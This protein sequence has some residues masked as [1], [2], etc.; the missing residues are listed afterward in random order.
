MLRLLHSSGWLDRRTVAVKVQFTLFSPTANL[1]T[2]VTLLTER[3]P[4]GVLLPSAKVQ[5]VRVYR[6][7]AVWDYVVM[8]C[9]VKCYNI[10][11]VYKN[12]TSSTLSSSFSTAEKEKSMNKI[13]QI[14]SQQMLQQH[15]TTESLK[16]LCLVFFLSSSSSSLSCLCC[17]SVIKCA[18]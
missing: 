16:V 6:T 10:Y 12:N 14:Y 11:F 18:H 8:V 2:S 13:Y 7:P 15:N 1:F 3:T 9:Q 4:T 5:S 17:K